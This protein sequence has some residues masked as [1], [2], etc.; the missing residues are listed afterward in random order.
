M[1]D[2]IQD[3]DTNFDLVLTGI[4]KRPMQ[5]RGIQKIRSRDVAFW[6]VKNEI[7]IQ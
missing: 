5:G 2:F 4:Q 3:T 7:K 6:V 1:N